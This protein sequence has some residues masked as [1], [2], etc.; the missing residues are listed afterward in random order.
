[1]LEHVFF[2]EFGC[3]CPLEHLFFL[4]MYLAIVDVVLLISYRWRGE[5]PE[6]VGTRNYIGMSQSDFLGLVF[7][8]RFLILCHNH[9]ATALFFCEG[10]NLILGQPKAFLRRSCCRRI[11]VDLRAEECSCFLLYFLAICEHIIFSELAHLINLEG[12]LQESKGKKN[13]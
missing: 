12:W 2:L 8:W 5:G 11:E 6:R 13:L 10:K 7:D 1:M 3:R 4:V 9:L